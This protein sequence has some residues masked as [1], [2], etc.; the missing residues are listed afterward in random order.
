MVKMPTGV[1]ERTEFHRRINSDG[2]KK[3]WHGND[4]AKR[5]LSKVIVNKNLKNGGILWKEK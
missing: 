2:H 4:D 3:Y 1:Y 5:H